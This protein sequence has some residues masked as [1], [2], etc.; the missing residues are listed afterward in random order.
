[1]SWLLRLLSE[2]GEEDVTRVCEMR[3]KDLFEELYMAAN[4]YWIVNPE[5]N[6]GWLS[7]G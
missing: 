1:M 4:T 5:D 7:V 6:R 2:N 3:W